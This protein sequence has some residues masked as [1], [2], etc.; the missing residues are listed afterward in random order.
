LAAGQRLEYR[1]HFE[2]I[3]GPREF[4]LGCHRVA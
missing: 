4:G 2:P 3:H 1:P